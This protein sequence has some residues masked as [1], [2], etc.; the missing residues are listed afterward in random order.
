M[1]L[2]LKTPNYFDNN[3]QAKSQFT[4]S[5]P[6]VSSGSFNGA[7]GENITTATSGRVANFYGNIGDGVAFDT[8]GLT[9]SNYN[10]T[11]AL[12]G[13]GGGPA[14]DLAEISILVPGAET[15]RIQEVHL[16]IGHTLCELAEIALGF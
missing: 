13:K 1:D 4:G 6:A 8:Q 16:L 9:G 15:A 12:L 14:K 3:G 7:S 2:C 11:I 10:N 5:L